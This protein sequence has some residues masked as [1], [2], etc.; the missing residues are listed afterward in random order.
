VVNSI[1]SQE[2]LARKSNLDYSDAFCYYLYFTRSIF[3]HLLFKN[4]RASYMRL[5]NITDCCDKYHHMPQWSS[6][7]RHSPQKVERSQ[8]LSLAEVLFFTTNFL[9]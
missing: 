2:I 1:I 9:Q 8:I 3:D 4:T 5:K 7:L 6:W